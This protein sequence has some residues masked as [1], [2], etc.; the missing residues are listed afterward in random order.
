MT[1]QADCIGSPLD[2]EGLKEVCSWRHECARR[3]AFDEPEAALIA[4]RLEIDVR[5]LERL[6]RRG[7]SPYLAL[8]IVR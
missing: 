5:V 4:H 2:R 6:I 1:A 7:C 3:L 8:E